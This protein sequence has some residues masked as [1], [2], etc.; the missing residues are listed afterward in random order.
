[1]PSQ[2]LKIPDFPTAAVHTPKEIAAL[3]GVS[4]RVVYDWIT[5]GW[6][7]AHRI[8]GRWLITAEDLDFFRWRS[9]GA[10][11]RLMPQLRDWSFLWPLCDSGA[12][13]NGK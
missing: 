12:G 8:G 5:Y 4:R 11:G 9:R 6:L 10:L 13:N 2:P 1:M 7:R 3:V